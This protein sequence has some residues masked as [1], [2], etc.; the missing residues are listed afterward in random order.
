MRVLLKL[1]VMGLQG[2]GIA[3]GLLMM[4]G[5]VTAVAG[6]HGTLAPIG[7]FGMGLF[8]VAFNATEMVT[9]ARE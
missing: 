2:L 4:I 1:S 7:W 8:L 5:G 9:I 3:A 6:G